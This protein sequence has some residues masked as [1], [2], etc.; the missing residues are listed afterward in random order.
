MKYKYFKY[1]KKWSLSKLKKDGSIKINRDSSDVLIH[2]KKEDEDILVKEIDKSNNVSGLALQNKV[3]Q[4]PVSISRDVLSQYDLLVVF[5]Y[6]SRVFEYQ[7]FLNYL[8]GFCL[9][10][11]KIVVLFD[12]LLQ[13]IYN[14][15]DILN[16]DR[17]KVLKLI[18]DAALIDDV[19]RFQTNSVDIMDRI[20]GK[21]IFDHPKMQFLLNKYQLILDSFCLSGELDKDPHGI[22]VKISGKA[23]STWHQYDSENLHNKRIVKIAHGTMLATVILA[24]AAILDNFD[25]IMV[26]YAKITYWFISFIL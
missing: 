7:N 14:K 16:R 17:M 10:F 12:E 8:F 1:F 25:K 18:I 11:T 19:R 23:L 9:G 4:T 2:V 22:N 21:R 15:R 3:Y 20:H 24:I 5:F 13:Q 6:K 26:L